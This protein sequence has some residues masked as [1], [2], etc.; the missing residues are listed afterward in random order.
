MTYK[1]IK[2]PTQA[3]YDWADLNM[4][5]LEK[6]KISDITLNIGGKLHLLSEVCQA[7]LFNYKFEEYS[8]KGE[9]PKK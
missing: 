2:Y 3:R 4:M 1:E 7:I 6:N 5:R 9:F 8:K